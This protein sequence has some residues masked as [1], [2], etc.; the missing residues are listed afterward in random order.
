MSLRP[1]GCLYATADDGRNDR[2]SPCAAISLAFKVETVPTQVG[3]PEPFQEENARL[4][5]ALSQMRS[6]MEALTTIKQDTS[7]RA[8][9][10]DPARKCTRD[11]PGAARE[12]AMQADISS[13]LADNERLM[14]MSNALRASLR[15]TQHSTGLLP[16]GVD[17]AAVLWPAGQSSTSCPGPGKAVVPGAMPARTPCASHPRA[18][19][20][21][22]IWPLPQAMPPWVVFTPGSISGKEAHLTAAGTNAVHATQGHS[23]QKAAHCKWQMA[24]EPL[25][26]DSNPCLQGTDPKAEATPHS[27]DGGALFNVAEPNAQSVVGN[28]ASPT[29]MQN[30]SGMFSTCRRGS[31]GLRAVSHSTR[32]G[33]FGI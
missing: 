11:N 10:N 4:R 28:C 24:A 15:Q 9:Q 33:W 8:G 31:G 22:A 7:A 17:L 21:H 30:R 26:S 32:H 23:L 12:A 1:C 5:M 18:D 16:P 25:S 14:E 3:A 13:L 2:A 27:G 29:N 19:A 6:H 20:S